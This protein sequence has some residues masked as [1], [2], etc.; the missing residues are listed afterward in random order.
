LVVVRSLLRP[1]WHSAAA[2][3]RG[4]LWGLGS[5]AR[6]PARGVGGGTGHHPEPQLGLSL[7]GVDEVLPALT[8]DLDGDELVALGGDLGLR[9][10]RPV[11]PVVDD[12]GRLFEVGLADAVAGGRQ[13]DPG[14]A[15]QVEAETGGPGP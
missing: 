4:L 8:G 11:D 1:R 7:D 3:Q 9:D 15:L 5:R 6:A 13:R 14:A 12:P 2:G 10:T